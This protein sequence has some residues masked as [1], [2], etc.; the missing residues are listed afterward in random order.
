MKTKSDGKI[1]KT[2]KERIIKKETMSYYDEKTKK[3]EI[4]NVGDL[5]KYVSVK[6]VELTILLN[7][8]EGRSE[9][10]NELCN[11]YECFGIVK[12]LFFIRKPETKDEPQIVLFIP[13][14]EEFF[15]INPD[16]YMLEKMS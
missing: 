14:E 11:K 5:V 10:V 3:S 1:K 6:R 2:V 12:K 15:T 16:T 8:I 4:L 13:K 7:K 9:T